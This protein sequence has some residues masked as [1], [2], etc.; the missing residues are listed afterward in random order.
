MEGAMR[1]VSVI[2]NWFHQQSIRALATGLLMVLCCAAQ[3]QPSG[4]PTTLVVGTFG[5]ELG[6]SLKE[7]YKPFETQYNVTIRW[8]PGESSAENVARVAATKAKPEFDLVFGDGMSFY[9]GVA[10]G[11]WADIDESI[12]TRYKDLAP[13]A[14]IP[15]HDVINYGFWLTGFFYQDKEFAKRGWK[16]PTKWDDLFRPEFCGRIGILNPNVSYGLHAVLMLGGGDPARAGEAIA[17]IAANKN[18]IPV[19][20]PT[21]AQLDQKIQLGDYLIGATGNIRVLP[22]IKKGAQVKFLIPDEGSLIGTSTLSA[23]KNSAHPQLDQEFLN[24]ILRPD[25]QVKLM[26]KAFYG[27]TNMTVAV[28]ADMAELG[29]PNM[30]VINRS[31]AIPDKIVY[32]N[33]RAWIREIERATEH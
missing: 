21:T 7:V 4:P 33:R 29:V 23:V 2:G 27:P 5:G 11:L 31:K 16:P 1:Q 22:Q 8:I 12:V 6:A 30:E 14:K 25:V 13:Q 24:W 9:V 28:P 18:C 32:D 19:L 15:S 26:E 10:Q 3:A 20:E 17:K